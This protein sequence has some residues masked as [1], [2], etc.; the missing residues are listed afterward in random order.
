MIRSR[1]KAFA[2]F[3]GQCRK[4]VSMRCCQ[5]IPSITAKFTPKSLRS[6][7]RQHGL[8]DGDRQTEW[9]DGRWSA[10]EPAQKTEKPRRLGRGFLHFA[11]ELL[12]RLG[13][14]VKDY[15]AWILIS[16]STPAGSSRR[17]SES[18]VFGDGS[19]MSRRRLWIFIWKCSRLS[20]CL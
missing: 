5:P 4:E 18:T 17:C 6:H 20:L 11:T 19:R 8:A 2:N 9:F 12:I 7:F 10:D 16:M 1:R 3:S 15:A 14:P 13:E